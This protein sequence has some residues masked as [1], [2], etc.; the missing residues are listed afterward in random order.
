LASEELQKKIDILEDV[1]AIKRLQYRYINSLSFT[2]WDEVVECFAE[3]GAV[4]L[5]EGSEKSTLVKGKEAIRKLFEEGV[6]KSHL[7][8]EGIFVV[9]PVIDVH[10]KTATGTWLSYFM[11][12]RSRGREPL[13]HWMQGIYECKY[14][15]ENNQWKFSLLKWKARLKYKSSQMEFLE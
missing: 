5:G 8:R 9:H 2:K 14:V 7:G 11:N 1:E 3:K 15:K 4:D 10:G 13:L 6:A 12:I